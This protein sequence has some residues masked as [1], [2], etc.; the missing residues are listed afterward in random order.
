MLRFLICS[1]LLISA[2]S[3]LLA[4]EIPDS[5]K[6]KEVQRID[7]MFVIPAGPVAGAF[8]SDCRMQVVDTVAGWAK[9]QVEGWVPVGLVLDRINIVNNYNSFNNTAPTADKVVRQQCTAI[10]KKG[11]RCSRMAQIGSD[12]CW[13]HQRGK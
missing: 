9:I 1:L 4:E 6:V 2:G 3:A 11:T 12:R 10:T 13:Q 8:S 5:L 7:T